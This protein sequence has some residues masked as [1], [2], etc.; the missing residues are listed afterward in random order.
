[1]RLAAIASLYAALS[2][3]FATWWIT[4]AVLTS[5]HNDEMIELREGA[6][7]AFNKAVAA[8]LEIERLN[9]A[10]AQKLELANAQ[11]R[12]TLDATLAENRRLSRE[13]G[14][15]RDPYAIA[16]GCAVSTSSSGPGI[17]T[18]NT[19]TGR[20]SSEAEEFLLTFARDADA[21]ANYA[22]T[23]SQFVSL[24]RLDRVQ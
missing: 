6:T 15:M 16:S 5:K 10:H 4:D 23:C 19:T 8:S 13:L 14:G 2:T 1:V 11:N 20:L 12:K 21:A 9:A 17:T 7:V 18:T 24:H 22:L 3:G